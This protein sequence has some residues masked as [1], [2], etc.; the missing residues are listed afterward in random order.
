MIRDR[1]QLGLMAVLCLAGC[2]H[3]P[4]EPEAPAS[5]PPA[6]LP[7]QTAQDAAW[8]EAEAALTQGKFA[9]AGHQFGAFADAFPD[10][11]RAELA[12]IQQ[13]YA[14]LADDPDPM[15]GTEQAAVLLARAHP[16]G[17]YAEEAAELKTVI[18][19]RRR[20]RSEGSDRAAEL[21]ACQRQLQSIPDLERDRTAARA[22]TAKLQQEL[23]RKEAAL[24]EVKQRLL[25]IQQLAAEM[26]KVPKP[27][28][29]AGTKPGAPP[30]KPAPTAKTHQ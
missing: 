18:E 27:P 11:P 23:V 12:R 22:A 29:G 8:E 21:E 25:E 17:S 4:P 16:D 5:P 14:A 1:A 7:P 6:S 20:L 3:A 19:T 30:A 24:E 28:A 26:L 2:A 13:A 9:E 15:R 10:E